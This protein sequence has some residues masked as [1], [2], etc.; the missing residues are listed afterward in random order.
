MTIH[1]RRYEPCVICGFPLVDLHRLIPGELGGEYIDN[2]VVCLCPNHH[3]LFHRLMR[4]GKLEY[5]YNKID[6]PDFFEFC[7][8]VM[9]KI[10]DLR[11]L[12][13]HESASIYIDLF[14]TV[15]T[16]KSRHD[17]QES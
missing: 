1:E 16:W 15:K 5:P 11:D 17:D 3:R 6:D 8:L 4:Q 13:G 10:V 9:P 7:E 14:L 2:N 12:D